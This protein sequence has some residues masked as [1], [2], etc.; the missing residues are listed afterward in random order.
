M[1][2][3]TADDPGGRDGLAAATRPGS[4]DAAVAVTSLFRSTIWSLSGWP[5]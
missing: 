5:W 4:G 1:S 3:A 2:G